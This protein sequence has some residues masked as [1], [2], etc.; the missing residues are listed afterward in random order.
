[1]KVIICGSREFE[2]Y[3]LLEKVC[4]YLLCSQPHVEVVSGCCRGADKLGERYAKSHSYKI[5]PFPA[6]WKNR[7]KK[8]GHERN[9]MMA[10]FANACIA[11]WDGKVKNS[12]TYDMIELA[13]KYKLKLAVKNI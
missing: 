10:Q 6:D 9:E 3:E 13:K 8:A 5:H 1:M 7:L 2:N 11:F 12:G 4:N